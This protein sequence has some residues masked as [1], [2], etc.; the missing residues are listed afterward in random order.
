MNAKRWITVAG[1][2]VAATVLA[3]SLS[4]CKKE[5]PA[6]GPTH[7]GTVEAA[8]VQTTCP[9]MG[10]PI[11]KDISVE[12]QGKTVYFCCAA[13]VDQFNAEP[14]KYLDKL[15]QFKDAVNEAADEAGARMHEAAGTAQATLAGLTEQ[16]TC[17]VMEGPINKDLF[18]EY[19]GKRVYF[20]CQ[21]CVDQ[22]NAEPEKYLSKLPQFQK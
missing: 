22:F 9:V 1:L 13:C 16:T 18:V 6:A 5:Q 12:Y 4:G 7:S 8:T 19:Q 3:W 2:S 21:A 14:E 20:C 15:P 11:N 10:N 17:P